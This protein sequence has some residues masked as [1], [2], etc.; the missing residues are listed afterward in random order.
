MGTIIIT[1]THIQARTYTHTHTP[2]L[3]HSSTDKHILTQ[4]N[5]HTHTNPHL[6]LHSHMRTQARACTNADTH[7]PHTAADTTQTVCVCVPRSFDEDYESDDLPVPGDIGH[8]MDKLVLSDLS[9][10]SPLAARSPWK[11]R[12]KTGVE[13]REGQREGWTDRETEGWILEAALQTCFFS[14]QNDLE[15]CEWVCAWVFACASVHVCV[16]E[17]VSECVRVRAWVWVRV[18]SRTAWCHISTCHSRSLFML[19]D[20]LPA[21]QLR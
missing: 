5:T 4:R 9:A 14:E 13:A 10:W 3:T 1:K 7:T 21:L 17:C 11:H 15:V 18:W 8:K 19:F 12:A 20:S 6:Y 16:C 2:I